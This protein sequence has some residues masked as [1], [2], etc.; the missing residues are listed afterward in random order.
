[1]Y[2]GALRPPAWFF[3]PEIAKYFAGTGEYVVWLFF[4]LSAILLTNK[5]SQIG[6]SFSE[7]SGYAIGRILRIIPLFFV[8]IIFLLVLQFG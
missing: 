8:V 1:M 4:V 5:F 6:F 7:L 3:I 2:N